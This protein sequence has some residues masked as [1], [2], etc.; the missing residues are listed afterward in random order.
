M[1]KLLTFYKKAI[2]E[3]WHEHIGLGILIMIALNRIFTIYSTWKYN[4]LVGNIL[5]TLFIGTFIGVAKE[6]YSE[7]K[8]GKDEHNMYIV[9]FSFA[10]VAATIIGFELGYLVSYF[11]L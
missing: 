2:L 3:N 10:D 9:P 8:G 4:G 1:K 7:V 11:W 6:M 5:L